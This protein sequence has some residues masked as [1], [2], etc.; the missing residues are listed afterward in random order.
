M[1]RDGYISAK[2]PNGLPTGCLGRP[3]LTLL[4]MWGVMGFEVMTNIF[5]AND[6]A[7]MY[8]ADCEFV[9]NFF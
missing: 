2:S 1:D 6:K 3:D 4:S 8:H 5:N 9:F 7:S